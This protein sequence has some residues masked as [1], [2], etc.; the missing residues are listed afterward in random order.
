MR[1]KIL[2]EPRR[3]IQE[4]L[5]DSLTRPAARDRETTASKRIQNEK[6]LRELGWQPVDEPTTICMLHGCYRRIE[7]WR[8]RK[9]GQRTEFRY[10][11]SESLADH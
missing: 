7:R 10:V 11:D 1:T 5:F 2:K 6:L 4:S 3:E 8:R 9:P